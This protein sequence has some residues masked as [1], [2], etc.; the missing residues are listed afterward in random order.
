MM[1]EKLQLLLRPCNMC[2]SVS[3]SAIVQVSK[4]PFSC[5]FL[6]LAGLSLLPDV[7]DHPD[8]ATGPD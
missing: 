6:N 8:P 7:D 3:S 1:Y 2:G 5:A 4:I